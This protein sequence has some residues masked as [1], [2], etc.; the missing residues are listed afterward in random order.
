LRMM[1]RGWPSCGDPPGGGS[2][3]CDSRADTARL[4]ARR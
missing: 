3:A 4:V 1:T 2:K